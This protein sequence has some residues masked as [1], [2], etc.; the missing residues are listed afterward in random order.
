MK[1]APKLFGPIG[2]DQKHPKR[3]LKE[4]IDQSSAKAARISVVGKRAKIFARENERMLIVVV[5]ND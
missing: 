1:C 4:M 3:W 5:L 2:T